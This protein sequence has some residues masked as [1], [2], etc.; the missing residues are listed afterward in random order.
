VKRRCKFNLGNRRTVPAPFGIQA[1][2]ETAWTGMT[3]FG[4][5]SSS[6]Q[7]EWRRRAYYGLLFWESLTLAKMLR[8]QFPGARL[9]DLLCISTVKVMGKGVPGA[10]SHT[11]NERYVFLFP[12]VERDGGKAPQD[13]S[14]SGFGNLDDEQ[15]GVGQ[16]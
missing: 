12:V 10:I 13:Q 7:F 4:I 6:L 9:S 1:R 5:R 14:G 16:R 15:H 11:E 2:V 3:G 8:H